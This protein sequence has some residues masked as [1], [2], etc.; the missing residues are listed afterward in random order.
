MKIATALVLLTIPF[1]LFAQSAPDQKSAQDKDADK[2]QA[3]AAAAQSGKK[4]QKKD[5]SKKEEPKKEEEKKGGMTADTFS[6]LHFRSIGPGVESG[7]VMS[8]AVNPKKKSEFT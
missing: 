5:Q 4:S 2:K 1:S 3:V 6:G 8:I 7:R